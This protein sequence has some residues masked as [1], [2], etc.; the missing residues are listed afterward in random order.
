MSGGVA[1]GRLAQERKDWRKTHPHGFAA[2]PE[3]L[4]DGTR[5]LIIWHCT[6]PGKQGPSIRSL[7]W[8]TG[9]QFHYVWLGFQILIFSSIIM[10]FRFIHNQGGRLYIQSVTGQ[11]LYELVA[12][13]LCNLH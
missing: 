13:A 7:L 9:I 2:K 5:N 12:V 11:D 10:N 4:P 6:I 1:R 8:H 3:T